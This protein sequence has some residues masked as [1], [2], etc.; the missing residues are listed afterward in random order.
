MDTEQTW[1]LGDICQE[2]TSKKNWFNKVANPEI[3]SKWREEFASQSIKLDEFDL[4]I[5]LLQATTQGSQHLEECDWNEGAMMCDNC[6]E[7]LK[8]DIIA[9]PDDFSFDPDDVLREDF[10]A[11]G[12]EYEYDFTD[13]A[14]DNCTHAY[15]KCTPPDS[16]INDYLEYISNGALPSELHNEWKQLISQICQREPIDWHPGSNQQVRDIIHPSLYCYVKGISVH[17][18][19]F[20]DA[21][22][23][24]SVLYQWLPSEF[25][26]DEEGQTK[27]VSYINNLN[28]EKYPTFIPLL[29]RTFSCFISSLETVLLKEIRGRRLQVITKVGQILLSS[30]KPNYMGGSW[31]IEGMPYER[32]VATCIHYVDVEGITDSYLEFR[33]PT[34]IN[35][36]NLDYPQSDQ[37]YTEHHYGLTDHHDGVMNRYL[38]LIKCTEGSSVVFPNTLQHRV[39]EFSSS[40]EGIRTILA[41]FIIDPDH[42]I[43]STADIPPQQNTLTNADYHRERLMYHRKYFV[44]QLNETVFTRPFSLCEH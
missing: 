32:I 22:C 30:D 42:R 14:N 15:C 7:Q 13:W 31:H 26:I 11:S 5:K 39:K 27:I 1:A 20:I 18:N 35:E 9:N 41:F 23:D 10:F 38:G 17:N 34:I 19:G 43:I 40:N 21:Q 16:S 12:W 28:H 44:N 3:V 36:E 29:E 33:K 4:A 24:E 2:I 37:K 6:L 25:D 8:Q